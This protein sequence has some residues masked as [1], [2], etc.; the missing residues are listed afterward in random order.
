MKSIEMKFVNYEDKTATKTF[1]VNNDGTGLFTQKRNGSMV[2]HAGT[3][4]FFA[5]SPKEMASKIRKWSYEWEK[6]KMI[7]NSAYGW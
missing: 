6:A 1:Y 2:Q 3:C 5:T 4:Q 7:R